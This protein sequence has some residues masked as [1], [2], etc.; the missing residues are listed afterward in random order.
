MCHQTPP[1]VPSLAITYTY[2]LSCDGMTLAWEAP[3]GLLILS[4]QRRVND[5]RV[6]LYPAY[7]PDIYCL[8]LGSYVMPK[9]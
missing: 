2:I 4:H 8:I 7:M 6:I 1:P 9:T 5:N 3:E